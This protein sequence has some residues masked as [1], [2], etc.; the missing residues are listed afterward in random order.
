MQ[1]GAQEEEEMNNGNLIKGK[2]TNDSLDFDDDADS[3][4]S[5]PKDYYGTTIEA[6]SL[7]LFP[8]RDTP[9]PNSN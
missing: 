9:Q 7:N 1:Q 4:N 3:K 6:G 2:S 5:L 8:T